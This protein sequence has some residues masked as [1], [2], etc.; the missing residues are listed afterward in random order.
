MKI[1]WG[2]RP[3]TGMI[4]I[5]NEDAA[6]VFVALSADAAVPGAKV[7]ILDVFGHGSLWIRRSRDRFPV[8]GT[9]LPMSGHDDPFLSQ[10]MPALFPLI[11]GAHRASS[12]SSSQRVAFW[13]GIVK[14]PR[15]KVNS[16]FI[17]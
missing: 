15:S 17:R 13:S 7:A 10:G 16:D 12:V 14:A 4:V 2:V 3:D 6:I 8:P 11:S 9:I 1:K 5:E